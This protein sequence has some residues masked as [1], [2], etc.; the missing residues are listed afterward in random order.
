MDTT[1]N[2]EF[3]SDTTHHL[4]TLEQQLKHIHD[5]KVDLLTPKDISVAPALIAIGLSNN[6]TKAEQAA[7]IVAQTLHSFLH[8]DE[9][10]QSQK[11]IFLVTKEGN[12]VD[13]EPLSTEEI[14]RIIV[15]A[16]EG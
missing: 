6:I 16:Q 4:K 2:I 8:E 11:K 15:E 12:R 13:I 14:E 7:H 1:V 5:V 9:A 10:T 3:T